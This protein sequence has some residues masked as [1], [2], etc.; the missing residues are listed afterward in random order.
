MSGAGGEKRLAGCKPFYAYG[1]AIALY[2]D[3][4][5]RRDAD[6]VCKSGLKSGDSNHSLK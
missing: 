5:G 2:A 4:A 3:Y 1:A 6:R